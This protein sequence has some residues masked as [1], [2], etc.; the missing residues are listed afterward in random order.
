MPGAQE[1]RTKKSFIV[2][3]LFLTAGVLCLIAPIRLTFEKMDDQAVTLSVPDDAETEFTRPGKRTVFLTGQIPPGSDA[4]AA[5]E[6]LKGNVRRLD[7]DFGPAGSRLDR[8]LPLSGSDNSRYG[9]RVEVAIGRIDVPTS[10]LYQFR[11]RWHPFVAPAEAD[12]VVK[13]SGGNVLMA[14]VL[15]LFG[16]LTLSGIGIVILILGAAREGIKS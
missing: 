3:G 4:D 8:V 5:T 7:V 13:R 15:G 16:L 2:A 11:T 10:G 6:A 9:D 14:W 12:I 1:P